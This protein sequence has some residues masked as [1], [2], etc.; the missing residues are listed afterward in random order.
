[1]SSLTKHLYGVRRN[2]TSHG[3][4]F[5]SREVVA[6]MLDMS[7]Y[8]PE[9]DLSE[10]LVLEPSFGE[11]DFL[12]E[13]QRRLI[14]SSEK[15]GFDPVKVFQSKIFACEIDSDKFEKA[16]KALRIAM[17]SFEPANFKNEDFLLTYWNVKF[18][19]VI[20]NP[21]YVRYENIASEKRELYKRK[22]VTFHYR[23]DLY[24]CFFEHSL[25]FLAEGGTHCFICSNRWMKNEYGRKLR[26]F[27]AAGFNLE[28]LIDVER[29]D[30]FKEM[31]LAYPGISVIMNSANNFRI[32]TATITDLIELTRPI[33][34]IEKSYTDINDWSEVFLKEKTDDLLSIE[35]QGFSIGIGV[36]TGADKVFISKNLPDVVE[37]ELLLPLISA[38]DLSAN[39]FCWQGKYLL[40]PY[41][42]NGNLVDIN[43]FPK[44]LEY[45]EGYREIIEKR[46][47]VRHNRK[48]Y[49]LIDKIKP[50]LRQQP[51]ILLPDISGNSVIFVDKGEFY[52]AHNIY[53]ISGKSIAW[54]E[55]LA[56]ILMS[57]FV[58]D[59]ISVI[60][61]KMNGSLPRWQSQ[62]IKKLRI[63]ELNAISSDK[64][65][66]LIDAYH[67][68]D[69]NA[70]N[71][72]VEEILKAPKRDG[73]P[74]KKE[75]IRQLSLFNC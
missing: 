59:Q 67:T 14:K 15:Y 35:E 30:A 72:I 24:V 29:L 66:R 26:A 70:I 8:V 39:D 46:H 32:K 53:Y 7:G 74:K 51:K 21:P 33:S 5:T 63:P 23:P 17:P 28:Y 49:A 18:D 73:A 54:L 64:R 12:L 65:K 40:N 48:W 47:I 52:P 38:K 60:S 37:K 62:S 43:D 27:I 55:M 36:A 71:S 31:V 50:G 34:Y 61:N 6:F 16:I 68:K 56:A 1:M 58:K 20:G 4:V 75:R 41:D 22:F 45:L 19:M 69:I 25:E 13:I 3:D 2:G 57:S 11:G 42:S 9:K 10:L 44:A